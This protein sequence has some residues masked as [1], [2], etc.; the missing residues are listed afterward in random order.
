MNETTKPTQRHQNKYIIMN[1]DRRNLLSLK[2]LI[3]CF[4]GGEYT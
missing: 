1:T 3:F 2:V 4:F